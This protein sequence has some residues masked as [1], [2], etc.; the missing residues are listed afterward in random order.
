MT[1]SALNR[2]CIVYGGIAEMHDALHLSVIMF[3]IETCVF[4]I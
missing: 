4:G 3:E 1:S 2:L